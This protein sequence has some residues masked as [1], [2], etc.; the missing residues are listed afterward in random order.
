MAPITPDRLTMIRD[1]RGWSI[2]TLAE[3]SGVS[4]RSIR[5]YESGEQTPGPAAIERL[6]Q[7]LGVP[8]S[9]FFGPPVSGLE[10]HAASFRA[11]TKLPVYRRRAAVAAGRMGMHFADWIAARFELPTVDIP[12]LSGV[13]PELA[14]ESVRA[15]WGIGNQPAPNI[16]QLLEA[17]GV[18]V[19]GLVQDCRE[20]DAFCFWRHGRPFVLLNTMKSGEHGRTDAAHELGHLILHRDVEHVTR[21]HEA[22]AMRFASAF[23]MPRRGMHPYGGRTLSLQQVMQIKSAWQVAAV[24]LVYR[25]HALELMVDWHY[26]TLIVELSKRGFRRS[27]PNGIVR[28]QSQL[29][30]AVLRLL[31]EEGVGPADIAADLGIFEQEIVEM[32]LGLTMVASPVGL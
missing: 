32:V 7:A 22:E 29:L 10:Q 26:R 24:A 6:G 28:E 12:D 20:V 3:R 30:P 31:R 1:R 27:E 4:V 18:V 15:A 25:L 9:W 21:E 13:D 16:V 5:F 19:F 8:P 2:N 23:L 11:A 14:A 17:H